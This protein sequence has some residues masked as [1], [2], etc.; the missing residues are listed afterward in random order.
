MKDLSKR[1]C[2]AADC[3]DWFQP[4][5]PSQKYCTKRCKNREGQRKLRDKAKLWSTM[6]RG[7]QA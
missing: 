1:R 5:L 3:R 2:E 4:K 6:V 7:Q